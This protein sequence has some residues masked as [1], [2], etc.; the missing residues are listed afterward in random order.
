MAHIG[1]RPISFEEKA[2]VALEVALA[3]RDISPVVMF[4]E[5]SSGSGIVAVVIDGEKRLM[6]LGK[7]RGEAMFRLASLV[8]R[9]IGRE[10]A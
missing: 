10:G 3:E 5:P 7:N 8:S 4:E 2:R 1:N 6:H 9:P